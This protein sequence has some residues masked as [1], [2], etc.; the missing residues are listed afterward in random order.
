V[1]NR[2][3]IISQHGLVNK[4]ENFA[5][6]DQL[7]LSVGL[8]AGSGEVDLNSTTIKYTSDSTA[9]NLVY[10]NSTT[11]SGT[12]ANSQSISDLQ[13]DEFTA[14][15]QNDNGESYPVLDEDSDR[16][17]L[18]INTSNVEGNGEGLQP[19]DS[20]DLEVTARSGGTTNVV[21]TIPPQ[22]ESENDDDPVPL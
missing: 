17:E 9:E 11:N 1:T 7:R 12:N 16:F 8:A 4:T 10:N 6:I 18:I 20:V 5:A 3:N 21:I 2:V 15:D 13:S 19:S 14:V 22:L